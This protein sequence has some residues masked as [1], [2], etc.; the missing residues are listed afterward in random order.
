MSAPKV[1]VTSAR[2]AA[3]ATSPVDASTPLGT[4]A[5]TTSAPSGSAGRDLGRAP[6]Q[7]AAAA[8]AEDA[9]EHQVDVADAGAV[10]DDPAAGPAQRVEPRLVHPVGQQQRLDPRRRGA[11]SSAPA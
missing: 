7:P 9:V 6:A 4:S 1:T 2:T 11:A 8:D 10:D 3:P 5:A